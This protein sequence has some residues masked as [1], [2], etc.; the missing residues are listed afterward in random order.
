[1]TGPDVV[2]QAEH[3]HQLHPYGGDRRVCSICG[4]TVDKHGR[5]CAVVPSW[6]LELIRQAVADGR[7]AISQPAAGITPTDAELNLD[8]HDQLTLWGA[9]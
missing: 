1:M 3:D 6:R 8:D 5:T 2:H 7:L 9:A 4:A